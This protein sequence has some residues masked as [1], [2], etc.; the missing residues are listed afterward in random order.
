MPETEYTQADLEL[1]GDLERA[2]NEAG[3]S[4]CLIGAGAIKLGAD[5]A[6]GVRLVRRTWDWDFA[7]RVSAWSEFED[8]RRRLVCPGGGF[9]RALEER[10]FRHLRGG[11]LDVVPYGELEDPPGTIEWKDGTR[12]DTAGLVVL[13]QHH[14]VHDL[15]HQRVRI[16]SLPALIG[17]KL[18]AYASRRDQTQR[19]VQDAYEVL[20]DAEGFMDDARVSIDAIDRLGSGAVEYGEVGAY[21]SG[22]DVGRTFESKA[23][24]EI[25]DVLAEADA[26]DAQIVS[27]VQRSRRGSNHSLA[28][29]VKRLKAFALGLEDR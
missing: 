22:R 18:L 20:L 19:D 11:T 29:I 27:D 24:E 7:V 26:T 16:A 2:A 5:L 25:L 10:R 13:D 12:M 14:E 1:F 6:W 9:E 23:R 21:L 28:L 15:D 8:L 3:V 17:L 4:V